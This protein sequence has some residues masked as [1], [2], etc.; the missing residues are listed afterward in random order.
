MPPHPQPNIA[1][2]DGQFY[3]ITHPAA[4]IYK[5]ELEGNHRFEQEINHLNSSAQFLGSVSDGSAFQMLRVV[6]MVISAV[7]I[8]SAHQMGIGTGGSYNQLISHTTNL[9]LSPGSHDPGTTVTI[10]SPDR[11]HNDG[12]WVVGPA[13]LYVKPSTSVSA[14]S[15]TIRWFVSGFMIEL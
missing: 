14:T 5:H 12:M 2:L 4:A 9:D 11:L 3:K 10:G 1:Y 15:L 13:T 6:G 7:S 8:V